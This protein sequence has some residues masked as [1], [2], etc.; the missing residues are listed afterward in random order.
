MFAARTALRSLVSLVVGSRFCH[1]TK[2]ID[3]QRGT[4]VL[5]DRNACVKELIQSSLL[6][7]GRWRRGCRRVLLCQFQP[8]SKARCPAVKKPPRP[9]ELCG[10]QVEEDRA[11]QRQHGK[12][13]TSFC[14]VAGILASPRMAS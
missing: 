3:T 10:L 7:T 9:G 14:Q 12:V 13:S 11:L 8:E 4:P 5:F 2:N 1:L 6:S